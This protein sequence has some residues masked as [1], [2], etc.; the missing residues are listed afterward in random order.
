M[1]LAEIDRLIAKRSFPNPSLS[2]A[3][4]KAR[5]NIS[6]TRI[7]GAF[8]TRS[9]IFN[10][11]FFCLLA[12]TRTAGAAGRHLTASRRC[13][14]TRSS[15]DCGIFL[16]F[17]LFFPRAFKKRRKLI[18]FSS[19]NKKMLG[20]TI[21]ESKTREIWLMR[22]RLNSVTSTWKLPPPAGHLGVISRRK[23]LTPRPMNYHENS[24]T[25]PEFFPHSQQ[26]R[27]GVC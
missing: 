13:K 12:L 10:E 24:T 19:N 7:K 2:F 6:W 18:F 1:N 8:L 16:F 4:D 11:R 22:V 3:S 27:S 26:L 17:F 5:L 25:R 14:L 20:F 15:Q 9:E 23:L 21:W